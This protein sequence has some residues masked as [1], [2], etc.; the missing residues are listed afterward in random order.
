ME[1][2]ASFKDQGLLYISFNQDQS[3]IVAGTERGFKIFD[4]HPFKLKFERSN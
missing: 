3:C 2:V 1:N 4:V